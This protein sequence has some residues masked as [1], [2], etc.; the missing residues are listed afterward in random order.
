MFSRIFDCIFQILIIIRFD[1]AVKPVV[2]KKKK[3]VTSHLNLVT[4]KVVALQK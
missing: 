4:K 2:Q 3:D 1:A